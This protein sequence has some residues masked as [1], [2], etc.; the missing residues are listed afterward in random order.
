[1]TAPET[2]S[3]FTCCARRSVFDVRQDIRNSASLSKRRRGLARD[4][5]NGE[6]RSKYWRSSRHKGNDI[7]D[8]HAGNECGLIETSI[9]D[10]DLELSNNIFQQ[11]KSW[12]L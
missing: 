6:R 7:R 4:I 12:Y 3:Y 9:T 1:M 11:G 8:L 2:S 10:G 5:G